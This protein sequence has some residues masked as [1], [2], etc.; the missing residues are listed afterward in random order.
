MPLQGG[1]VLVMLTVINLVNFMD[2]GI[3]PGAPGE[4]ATFVNMSM[5]VPMEGTAVWTGAIFSSFVFFYSI[6]SVTYGHLI[7]SQPAFRLLSFGLCVWVYALVG[8]GLAYF[9]RPWTPFAFYWYLLHRALSGVGE[10]AFQCIVP[11]Y[12]EDIAPP[13]S[14][15]LWLG[16]FYTA[17]P[18]GTAFGFVYGSLLA[19][20]PPESIGWGWAYL[21]EA[22]AMAPCAILVAWLPKPDEI[23]RRRAVVVGARTRL[24][25][26]VSSV[27]PSVT[28]HREHADGAVSTDSSLTSSPVESPYESPYESQSRV[29]LPAE[30]LPAPHAAASH[31]PHAALGGD[32]VDEASLGGGVC[33][34]SGH[35][36]SCLGGTYGEHT[37]LYQLGWLLTTPVYVLLV[38]GYAAQTATVMGI[39]TFGPNFVIALGLFEKE[40]TGA[41]AFGACAALGGALGTPLGGLLADWN[42][43]SSLARSIAAEGGALT[44][45]RARLL[46]M[47]ALIG[48]I[49]ML[50]TIAGVSMVGAGLALYTGRQV[51]A[52]LGLI[53]L[54]V[55][56]T[57][58]CSAGISRTVMRLVP[59][60]MRSFALAF[61]ASGLGVPLLWHALMALDCAPLHWRSG[62]WPRSAT[63]VACTAMTLPLPLI[64]RHRPSAPAP[65]TLLACTRRRALTARRRHAC[66]ALGAFVR[67]PAEARVPR[68]GAAQL[69]PAIHAAPKGRAPRPALRGRLHAHLLSVLEPRL[70]P[71]RGRRATRAARAP[72]ERLR[73]APRCAHHQR[74]P[75]GGRVR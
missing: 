4:F 41:L 47:R 48:T 67:G 8:S 56:G 32:A 73:A 40:S 35:E 61:Q 28:R 14:K 38:L 18:C 24:L 75:G 37:V 50:I 13:G 43:R 62:E 36:C 15:A 66:D 2:R 45:Q 27:G 57:Y 25:G 21:F 63:A 68:A 58:A 42:A 55:A 71:R 20:G 53:T 29:P 44:P 51:G 7:N 31:K 46:E 11:P 59:H 9:L 69:G 49:T 10:A 34:S 3:T 54:G 17:I 23:S 52:F 22:I 70:H 12:I 60:G 39:S 19:P 6:A 64:L 72:A 30:P 65:D 1:H 33:A 5:G 26:E 74:R 16:C